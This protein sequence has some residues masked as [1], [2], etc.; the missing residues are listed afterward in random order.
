MDASGLGRGRAPGG[1][2]VTTLAKKKAAKK[3]AAKKK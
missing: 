2:E 3:K 1:K